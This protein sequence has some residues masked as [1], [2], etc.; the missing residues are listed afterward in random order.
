MNNPFNRLLLRQLRKLALDMEKAPGLGGWQQFLSMVNQAYDDN[1]QERY[2]TERSLAI[3]SEEMHQLYMQQKSSYETRLQTIFDTM[4]DL[5]WLKDPDGVY[6]ACNQMF[7]R[8]FGATQAEIVGKTDYDFV[9]SG[10]ADFFRERDRIAMQQGAPV[11]NE[12]WVT[13]A[14]DGRRVL[15]E[16][17]KTPMYNESG[18][19]IGVLGIGRDITAHKLAEENLRVAAIAFE[20]QEGIMISDAHNI[21]L[22]VNRAFSEI[23][24][25]SLDDVVGRKPSLLKSGK[26]DA[27]FYAIMWQ[28]I[29]HTGGWEGE[30]WNKRK[31]GELFPEYLRITVVKDDT[32]KI[33]NYVA[34]FTDITKIKAAEEE[35]K[36]LAYFDALTHLPNRRLLID[37]LYQAVTTAARTGRSGSVLF[38][39]LDNFKTLNDTLGHD[40]GDMLLQQVARRLESCVREVDTVA[41]LGGDE[42]VVMLEDLSSQSVEAA[43]QVEMVAEKILTE[44]NRPYL[45]KTYEYHNTSSIGVTLFN[46]DCHR[47]IEEL[48]KQAD[49]AMYQAKNAGRNTVRFFDQ[50]MQDALNARASLEDAL[51]GALARNEFELF[52]Q[53]QIDSFNAPIGAEA[54]IRWHRPEMGKVLPDQFIPVAEESNLILN[55]GQWVLDQACAQIKIWQSSPLTRDLVMAINVSAKQFRR[56]DFVETLWETVRRH[57][58]SPLKLKLELTESMLQKDIDQTIAMMNELKMLGFQFSLDDFGTGYSSLQYLKQLPLDQLKIDQSFVRDLAVDSSDQAIVT[59]IIAVANS[60]GLAVIAEGVE[61]EEQ[62]DLLRQAHCAQFQGYLFGEPLPLADFEQTLLDFAHAAKPCWPSKTGRWMVK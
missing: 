59:T 6:M 7:E 35:I 56:A 46:K 20:A 49:I 38:L 11:V 62:Y 17:T 4:Q 33:T 12:E 37:R 41:R 61:T 29:L 32:G 52:Y 19:T 10:L 54:L 40:L 34:T 26:Q 1:D 57:D 47:S 60:L 27:G 39:D 45:L 15:L 48:M 16:T 53:V 58:V 51:R 31:N 50:Q 28:S 9:D 24:G 21:I 43:T 14:Q 8:F 3:S 13:F 2:I 42:F 36:Y 55:I 25:Y 30:I 5:L 18:H 22:R 23:T 44:I